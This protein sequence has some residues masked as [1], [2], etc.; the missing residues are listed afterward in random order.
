MEGAEEVTS[1]FRLAPQLTRRAQQAYAAMRNA[2]AQD[3]QRVK[4]A[5]LRCYNISEE[6]Y[7]QRFRSAWRKDGESYTELAVRLED[8]V[9]KWTS[10]C[11]SMEEILEKVLIEQ[12]LTMMPSDLRIWVSE[13][14]PT[15]GADADQLADNYY[16]ARCHR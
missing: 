6:T 1:A 12:I 7:R 15:K 5:I 3:Y 13:R 2:D 16:Q 14:K 9:H 4:E 11:T 10:G 8:L